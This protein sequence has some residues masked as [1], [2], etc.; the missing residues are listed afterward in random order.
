MDDRVVTYFKVGVYFSGGTEESH[1]RP[2]CLTDAEHFYTTISS[3]NTKFITKRAPSMPGL[4][5]EGRK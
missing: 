5:G 3:E 2:V 1:S 4:E